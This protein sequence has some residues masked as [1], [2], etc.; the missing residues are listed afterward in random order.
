M[1]TFQKKFGTIFLKEDSEANQFIEK[2]NHLSA[3]AAGALKTE[4]DKQ[5]K[6]AS[7]RPE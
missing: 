7:N 2:M 3:Q 5:V 6:L 4:I 1:F